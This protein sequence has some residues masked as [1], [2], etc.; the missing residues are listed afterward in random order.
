MPLKLFI[1]VTQTLIRGTLLCLS[2]FCGMALIEISRSIQGKYHGLLHTG[3]S[4]WKASTK[5]LKFGHTKSVLLSKYT[6]VSLWI[7]NNSLLKVFF[8][9][10]SKNARVLGARSYAPIIMTIF[11]GFSYRGTHCRGQ[12]KVHRWRLSRPLGGLVSCLLSY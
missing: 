12:F 5:D 3:N 11:F 1:S 10:F 8:R 6:W 4:P 9:R 2:A 7:P